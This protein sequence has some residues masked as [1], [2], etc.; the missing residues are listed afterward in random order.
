MLH[1]VVYKKRHANIHVDQYTAAVVEARTPQ[2]AI[3]NELEGE[4]IEDG[5]YNGFVAAI[6]DD[7]ETF[8]TRRVSSVEVDTQMG[9]VES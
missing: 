3:A 1:V 7:F 5:A 4:Y 8:E 2:E 9:T 6:G